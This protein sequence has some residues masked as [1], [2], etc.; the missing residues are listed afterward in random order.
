M[1]TNRIAPALAA[2]ALL[3]LLAWARAPASDPAPSPANPAPAAKPPPTEAEALLDAALEKVRGVRAIAARIHEDV[4]MLGLAYKVEGQYLKA[5]DHRIY[6]QLELTGLGDSPGTMLLV[7]DGATLWE[8]KKILDSADVRK[9]VL[10]PIFEKLDSPDCT[11]ELR[12]QVLGQM[13]F[14][15]P[16][17]LLAGLRKAIE[18]NQKDEDELDGTKVWI[19]RGRW[20]DRESI[21]GPDA[22]A[23]LP[24]TGPL[25]PY[26]P[27]LAAVWLGQENGWPYRV[28]LYGQSP[29]I[30]AKKEIRELGPDGRPVGRPLTLPDQ[31]PSA[32][33]LTY[34]D[35]Q[36]DPALDPGQFSWTPP[37]GMR[38]V[39]ETKSIV[40]DLATALTQIAAQR[41]SE[42]ATKAEPTLP[43]IAVPTPPAEP[44]TTPPPVEPL[45]VIAPPR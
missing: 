37:D 23:P 29:G 27:S 19:L 31:P 38:V 4:K 45:P 28:E 5:P 17:A 44:S 41:K 12:T 33:R 8:Y 6:L 15:G 39:D 2:T 9:R 26:V 21:T 24:P 1:P 14:A 10:G 7:C 34:T 40:S 30:M 18:F 20:K 36:V 25:P 13:G 43:A 11:P 42:A 32:I 22:K 16:D 35:V 3:P